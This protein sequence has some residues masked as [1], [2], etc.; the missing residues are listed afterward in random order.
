MHRSKHDHAT[1]DAARGGE[2]VVGT[3]RDGT[4]VDVARMGHDERFRKT[5]VRLA[6]F[7]AAQELFE[8]GGEGGRIAGIEHA[9]DGGGAYGRHIPLMLGRSQPASSSSSTLR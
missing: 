5:E 3:R 1:H 7:H 9:G 4:G 8:L 6:L 2:L